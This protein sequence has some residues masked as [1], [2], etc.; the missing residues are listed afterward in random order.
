MEAILLR[1]L[2][3]QI[4][5]KERISIKNSVFYAIYVIS[6]RKVGRYNW[7]FLESISESLE[8]RGYNSGV[9]TQWIRLNLTII[10]NST[11]F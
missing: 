6:D 1:D 5:K 3:A 9:L 10:M 4:R 11:P 8:K 2:T 7:E